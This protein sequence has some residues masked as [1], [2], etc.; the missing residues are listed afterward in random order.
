ML[1]VHDL[2]E[3]DLEVELFLLVGEAMDEVVN[4]ALEFFL[5]IPV[6]RVEITGFEF[7]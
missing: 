5:L 3:I 2:G 7:L 1:H 4:L 6:S